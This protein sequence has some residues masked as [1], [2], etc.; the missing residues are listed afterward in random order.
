M[1]SVENNL[2]YHSILNVQG[3]FQ[4]HIQNTVCFLSPRE[5]IV[6]QGIRL[7]SNRKNTSL[8]VENNDFFF[9]RKFVTSLQTTCHLDVFEIG[10]NI[11]VTLFCFA[12]ARLRLLDGMALWLD[13][14]WICENPLVWAR[15]DNVGTLIT[16][17]SVH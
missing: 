2:I 13:F 10:K 4:R 5:L 8:S 15:A 17:Y 16:S 1:S 9:Q 14:H 6:F 7:F 11:Y 12:R 3:Y